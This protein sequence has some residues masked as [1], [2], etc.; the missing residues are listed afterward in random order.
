MMRKMKERDKDELL[1]L[2]MDT[3]LPP[4]QIRDVERK[5][6]SVPNADQLPSVEKIALIRK[7]LQE[8]G[9][10]KPNPPNP[11]FIWQSVRASIQ[12]DRRP[13]SSFIEKVRSAFTIP[14]WQ[15]SLAVI[16]LFVGMM[17]FWEKTNER[18]FGNILDVYSF[19]PNVTRA[20]L[21][22]S[23]FLVCRI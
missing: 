10:N 14:R 22:S 23:G 9:L 18:E 2:L 7:T 8:M 6:K 3:K 13:Q 11:D 16:A 21:P 19:S 4:E 12:E 17:I 15:W 1:D 20:T 5:L